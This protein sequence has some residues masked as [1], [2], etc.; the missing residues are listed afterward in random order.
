MK[1]LQTFLL[2]AHFVLMMIV[3]GGTIFSVIVEYP[4]WFADVPA[5]LE[6]TRN[7]YKVF[8]PGYFFQTFGPLTL[9]SG[10]AFIVAGWQIKETRNLV[11]ASV[12]A[13]IAIEL[14]TFIYIYPRL[15]ILF[16]PASAAHAVDVLRRASEEFTTA[17]RIRTFMA[18]IASAL[19]IA[20]LLRFFKH[21]NG[22]ENGETKTA[23]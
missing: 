8:H 20:A 5:S 9:L 13:M 19:S 11:L 4:N 10:L 6:V 23:S 2:T 14:L 15:D 1:T 18:L 21:R 17:D 12:V 22:G 7:F 16:G 3:L